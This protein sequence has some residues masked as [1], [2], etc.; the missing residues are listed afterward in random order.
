MLKHV[1][2]IKL[3]D[4]SRASELATLLMSLDGR[5]ETLKSIEV[6]VDVLGSERSWDLLLVTVFDSMQGMQEYQKH[7][8]HLEVAPTLREAAEQIATVD[9]E[10]QA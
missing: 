1:V 5:V 2:C 8:A 7:P 3:K 9:Y 6:G 4:R 10:V